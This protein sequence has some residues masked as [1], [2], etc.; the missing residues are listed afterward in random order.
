[1][2]SIAPVDDAMLAAA[3]AHPEDSVGALMVEPVGVMSREATAAEAVGEI[4]RLSPENLITYLYVTDGEGRLEGVVAMREILLAADTQTLGE[5]MT[6]EPFV[7]RTDMDLVDAM[8]EAVGRHYPVYPVCDA[9]D[10]LVGLVR[11]QLLFERRAFEISAQP[12]QMVGVEK[13]ERLSTPLLQCWRLRYP[14][15]QFNLLT[16]F[17]AAAVVATFQ[18]TL[19]RLVILAIFL[20]VLAGQSGNTGAQALAVT[21]RSLTLGEQGTGAYRVRK[22]AFLGLVNGILVALT[23]GLTMYIYASLTGE[24]ARLGLA[25]VVFFAMLISC[26]LSGIIGAVVPLT[27]RRVGTD[28]AT[29]SSIFLTTATDVISMALLLG[30]AAWLVL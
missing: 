6:R 28:P 20:P 15:L 7:L 22:E 25:L 29:A 30:L 11:G 27:L 1:M 24:T 26:I 10:R 21:L 2:S 16:A 9:D 18:S 13:E 23:A 19:D 12:G 14:W 5:L 3:A 17:L 4:R 8:R